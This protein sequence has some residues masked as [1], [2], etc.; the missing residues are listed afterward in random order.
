M[1]NAFCSQEGPIRELSCIESFLVLNM[2]SRL[3]HK[4]KFD[5]ALR[6]AKQFNL[7]IEVRFYIKDGNV[8]VVVCIKRRTNDISLKKSVILFVCFLSLCTKLRLT[9]FLT[10][11]HHGIMKMIMGKK[12]MLWR[13]FLSQNLRIASLK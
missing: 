13:D 7:D 4:Q 11:C 12:A 8:F 5:E 2:L 9:G 6:F 3:L 1:R 10:K